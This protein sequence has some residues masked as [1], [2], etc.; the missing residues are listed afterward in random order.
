MHLFAL[1]SSHVT[2]K[3]RMP[4]QGPGIWNDTAAVKCFVKARG[5]LGNFCTEHQGR[6]RG[7]RHLFHRTLIKRRELIL[8][9]ISPDSQ[10]TAII[11]AVQYGRAAF[12]GKEDL[13]EAVLPIPDASQT[14]L[15]AFI[16]RLCA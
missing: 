14:P 1:R 6:Q 4:K 2:C 15:M 16:P 8:M 11:C 13:W 10:E 9:S 3:A 12:N 7:R 5:L